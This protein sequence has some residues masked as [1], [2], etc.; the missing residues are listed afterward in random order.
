[1]QILLGEIEL[2]RVPDT[3]LQIMDT[4]QYLIEGNR[5]LHVRAVGLAASGAH[6][7]LFTVDAARASLTH[8]CHPELHR[9]A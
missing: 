8:H 5:V 6:L 3:S 7:P 2:H 4:L 1:M 9:A